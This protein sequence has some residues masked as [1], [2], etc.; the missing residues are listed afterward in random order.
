MLKYRYG[1]KVKELIEECEIEKTDKD[2]ILAFGRISF[3]EFNKVYD[4][5]KTKNNEQLKS[6]MYYM[7]DLIPIFEVY[8]QTP[9]N[10]KKEVKTEEYLKLMTRLRN[11]EEEKNYRNLINRK[12]KFDSNHNSNE[13]IDNITNTESVDGI[14]NYYFLKTSNK[15]QYS[16]NSIGGM[17]KEIKHQITTIF[18]IMITVVSVG[19]AVWYWS[20]S[21][22][23]L[24]NSSNNNGIRVLLSLIASLITL[25]AEVVVFGGYLRKIEDAREKESKV[26]ENRTI[27][28]TIVIKG[29]GSPKNGKLINRKEKSKAG[30]NGKIIIKQNNQLSK[31]NKD[32]KVL[33]SASN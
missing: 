13:K 4:S 32:K 11:E 15:T 20:G 5:Y 22:M 17:A 9:E 12:N 24:G 26:V 1:Q 18:N 7:S 30:N 27:V 19:Y 29:K 21:S 28:Q 33:N 6:R 2:I 16:N 14:G 8:D 3:E 10:G 31:K 23:G 25:V